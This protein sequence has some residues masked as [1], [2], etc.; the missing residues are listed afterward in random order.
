[1]GFLLPLVSAQQILKLF[2]KLSFD[3]SL[4]PFLLLR[5]LTLFHQLV[6]L[7]PTLHDCSN[8]LDF[9]FQRSIR[10]SYVSSDFRNRGLLD[11]NLWIGTLLL[12]NWLLLNLRFLRLSL[13]FNLN[14]NLSLLLVLEIFNVLMCVLQMLIFIL[15]L[16]LGYNL[17]LRLMFNF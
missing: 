6:L 13:G 12:L 3:A 9:L 11:Y 14:L 5:Q 16:I 2:G 10:W 4:L 15:G 7:R 17:R 1:M 8:I